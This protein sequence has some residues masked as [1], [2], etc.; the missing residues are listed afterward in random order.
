MEN[1][2]IRGLIDKNASEDQ[3]TSFFSN[4]WSVKFWSSHYIL[5][6]SYSWTL[7]VFLEHSW[8][9]VAYLGFGVRRKMKNRKV[10]EDIEINNYNDFFL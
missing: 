3:F 10:K 1:E 8:R 4:L 7:R 2:E 9:N 6:L 5:S